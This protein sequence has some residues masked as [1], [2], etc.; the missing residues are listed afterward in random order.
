[1]KQNRIPVRRNAAQSLEYT[2]LDEDGAAVN[3]SNAQ[4][5]YCELKL[6]GSVYSRVNAALDGPASGG[7]VTAPFTPDTVGVWTAQFFAEDSLG[8]RIPG[9]PV[10]FKVVKNV[11][12]LGLSELPSY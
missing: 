3:L 2:F 9:E 12:D 10:R 5:L 8:N 11:E 1:M 4:S 6:E 7:S